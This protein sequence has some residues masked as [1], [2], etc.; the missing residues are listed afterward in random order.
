[1]AKLNSGTRIYGNVTV[2]TFVTATGNVT[3]NYFIGNGSQLT[4]IAAS[5]GNANVVANLAALGS[6]PVSTTGNITAGNILG[7]ANVNAT[8]HTGT[9]VS[10][11]GNITGGNILGGAN[12]NATTHTGTTASLSGNVTGGNILTGGLISS[13]GNITGGNILGG[14]NVNATTHTGTTVSVTGNITGGNVLGGANVNATSLT[15]TTVSVSGNITGGNLIIS[16]SI[17]DSAQLD[18][19]T[20]SANANIVL[21]PN[22]TGNV[23]TG[24]NVSVTG[25][26]TGGN[27]LG[28][29][30]V[31]A[32]THTGTTV[33]V[34]GNITGGNILTAGQFVSTQTGATGNGAAQI[35]LNGATLNRIDYNQNGTGAP[36]FTT[37]SSGTKIV[38]YPNIAA[39]AADY[40][41]G[42]EAGALW[43]AVPT[44]SNQ[45]KWYAGTTQVAALG[46]GGNL[47]VAGTVTAASVVGGVMTGSSLSVTGNITGGNVLGGANVNA[48]THTGTTVSVTGNITGGNLIIS[49]SISDSAQLDIQTTSANANIVLTPNGTGN[50]N[51]GA[52]VS[53]TGNIQGGNLRTAGLISATGAITGAAITGTSL[54]VSTGN[55]TL[56]NVINANGNA[57]GNIGS[58]ALYFNTVFAKATSAQYADL[59]EWYSADADYP[60]GTVLS[61]GGNNE[62]T[63]TTAIN[64]PKIAGVVSTNPAHVMNAGLTSAHTVMVALAGRVPTL[65]IG[66]VARGDMMVSAGGGRAKACATPA[67]GTVIGKALQNHPGGQGTIE[68]VIGRI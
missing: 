15:G 5:Y 22:G 8:T 46:G 54:T 6:N 66:T 27:I 18:I 32:T 33:S 13:T 41:V 7:G 44:T 62:V 58:A 67:M 57:V 1:M 10:V 2:D 43:S 45:F 11:S 25:N 35:Y 59:A 21:T 29:A 68:V 50:I 4:G 34:S 26:I 40:A 28:G 16:G 36:T 49:G 19:Q 37:R 9:T 52:N 63:M 17:S 42:V 56:G 48:T 61:F 65:V 3:G 38:L 51:T 55:V 64:D 53:V 30:N 47:S 39:A 12:V 31:N 24:A 14:A 60:P 20:T 23:N